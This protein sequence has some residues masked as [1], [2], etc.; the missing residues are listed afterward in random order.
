MICTPSEKPSATGLCL[1]RLMVESPAQSGRMRTLIHTGPI[2]GVH[3]RSDLA[4]SESYSGT[5]QLGVAYAIGA[6][7]SCNLSCPYLGI[8]QIVWQWHQAFQERSVS[9]S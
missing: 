8:G 4:N 1:V 2:S 6:D 9:G 5:A 3:V 7:A